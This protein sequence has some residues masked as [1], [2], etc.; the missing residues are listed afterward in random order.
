MIW[1]RFILFISENKKTA[2]L[3]A[4][5]V[6][7]ELLLG[8][9]RDYR[10]RWANACACAAVNASIRVYNVDVT[11]RYRF[12]GAFVYTSTAS[13]A[14]VCDFVSHIRKF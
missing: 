13:D 10:F 2:R 1:W 5:F 11:R 8:L 12:N 9:F 4:A 3:R 6:L 14:C 7:S